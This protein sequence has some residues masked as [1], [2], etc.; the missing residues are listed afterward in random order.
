[1]DPWRCPLV[2]FETVSISFSMDPEGLEA[3]GKA[4]NEGTTPL[5]VLYGYWYAR[6]GVARTDRD[7]RFGGDLHPAVE[8]VSIAFGCWRQLIC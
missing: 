6:V 3:R 5:R 1:M 7:H 8:G 4:S 2:R